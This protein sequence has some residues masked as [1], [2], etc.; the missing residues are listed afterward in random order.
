MEI[1]KE[2][3]DWKKNF[4][5]KS[6]EDRWM[7]DYFDV[8]DCRWVRSPFLTWNQA[9]RILDNLNNKKFR[10]RIDN[11]SNE[12]FEEVDWGSVRI[13]SERELDVMVD[14]NGNK[15]DRYPQDKDYKFVPVCNK[16]TYLFDDRYSS[17]EKLRSGEIDPNRIRGWKI[18]EDPLLDRVDVITELREEYPE[19]IDWDDYDG[20]NPSMNEQEEIS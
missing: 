6:L 15:E 17:V 3:F 16:R 4:D 2:K 12:N 20:D 11:M 14:K 8:T 19:G 10:N 5:E 1:K 9:I 18:P 13:H 7:L